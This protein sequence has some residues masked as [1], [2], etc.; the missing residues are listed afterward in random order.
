MERVYSTE[1]I[2]ADNNKDILYKTRDNVSTIGWE[3][4]DDRIDSNNLLGLKSS[5]QGDDTLPC[6][7]YFIL[8]S[9]P[10]LLWLNPCIY[11][12]DTN[13]NYYNRFGY[14]YSWSY[15]DRLAGGIRCDASSYNN[16]VLKGNK[17]FF[18][19]EIYRPS[20]NSSTCSMVFKID[21]TLWDNKVATLQEEIIPGNDVV[22]QLGSGES[23]YFKPNRNYRLISPLGHISKP[24][25]TGID[26]INDKII[27]DNI[28]YTMV[29]GT[30]CGPLPFPWVSVG[31]Y[32]YTGY[33]HA[34]LQG[35]NWSIGNLYSTGTTSS[36]FNNS[37]IIKSTVENYKEGEYVLSPIMIS[38]SS[39]VL[40]NSSYFYNCSYGVHK[41]I[42]G[43]DE[44]VSGQVFSSTTI[45]IF[46][47][48]Q[49]WFVDSLKDMGIIITSGEQEYTTRRIISNTYNTLTFDPPLPMPVSG[50][51]TY[52][53]CGNF[54]RKIPDMAK[55]GANVYLKEI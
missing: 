22:A 20:T 16:I 30:K 7:I 26:T 29:S 38:D 34:D 46:D 39:G 41:D 27:F 6:Y 53:V 48:N 9:R 24:K 11:F 3:V 55:L 44:I 49:G 40:G 32:N 25:I 17:C 42:I 19:I 45:E 31:K 5:E 4:V 13:N 18:Y 1:E 21:N 33:G 43:V 36:F 12:N 51:E 37:S 28:P 23:S 52:T 14:V 54:Y 10:T 35:I 15:D 50:S 47:D 2:V 8:T